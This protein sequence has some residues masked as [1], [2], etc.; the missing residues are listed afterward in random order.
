MRRF[1]FL[2][3]ALLA[4][5]LTGFVLSHPG[6][7]WAKKTNHLAARR[8]EARADSKGHDWLNS[9]MG[10]RWKNCEPNHWRGYMLQH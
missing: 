7:L 2:T 9:D 10:R 4:V 3:S 6:W 8:P 5:G 1:N